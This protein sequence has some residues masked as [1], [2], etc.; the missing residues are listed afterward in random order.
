M[1]TSSLLTIDKKTFDPIYCTA[2]DSVEFSYEWDFTWHKEIFHYTEM[3]TITGVTI[4]LST[5]GIL[6]IPED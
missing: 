2:G 6:F 4:Y 1:I 5:D 3:T